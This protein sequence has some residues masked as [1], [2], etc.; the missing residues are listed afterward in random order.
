MITIYGW[1]I[2]KY[3]AALALHSNSST[4]LVGAHA[5]SQSRTMQ[6]NARTVHVFIAS[7]GDVEERDLVK[8]AMTE[9][10]VE[11]TKYR[12]I[13]FIPEL[14]EINSTSDSRGRAQGQIN[15]KLLDPCD[16]LIA[17]F[18]KKTGTPTKVAQSG[19]IEEITR[20]HKTK[21]RVCLF[22]CERP[23]EWRVKKTLIEAAKVLDLRQKMHSVDA[24]IID[25]YGT[26][27]SLQ[28]K[29]RRLFN[30]IAREYE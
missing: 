19:T 12:N 16:V 11:N 18:W 26:P 20:F 1:S 4:M 7:P 24:G 10:N 29:L 22:F 28:V 17:L 8:D 14:W 23:L 15:K 21:K 5:V 3:F 13:V 25:Y 9:W 2:S 30:D 27:E 6:G